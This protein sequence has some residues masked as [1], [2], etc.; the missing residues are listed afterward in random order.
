MGRSSTML[1]VGTL[2]V[3]DSWSA[4][5]PYAAEDGEY[6]YHAE[7]GASFGL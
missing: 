6:F 4:S 2:H 3:A 5:R 1:R 7:Q